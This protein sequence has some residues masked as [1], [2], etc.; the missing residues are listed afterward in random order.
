MKSLIEEKIL[1]RLKK[2]IF[3]RTHSYKAYDKIP[4][5]GM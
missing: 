1:Q 5:M 3:Y 2:I 4:P